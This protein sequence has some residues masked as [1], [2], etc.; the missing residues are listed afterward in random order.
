MNAPTMPAPDWATRHAEYRRLLVL[1]DADLTFGVLAEAKYAHEMALQRAEARCATR[2]EALAQRDVRVASRAL[3][4]AEGRHHATYGDVLESAAIAAVLAPAPD[5]EAVEVKMTL[6]RLFE[7]DNRRDMPLPP[8]EVIEGDLARLSAASVVDISGDDR[9]T[10]ATDQAAA[11]LINADQLA[12][13]IASLISPVGH[14]ASGLHQ[15][16]TLLHLQQDEIRR[17]AEAMG[18]TL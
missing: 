1:R 6:I 17:A 4:V 9:P 7:L 5:L 18:G 15:A 12:E 16:L 14:T 10:I 3:S 13:S 11:H 8:M 2:A